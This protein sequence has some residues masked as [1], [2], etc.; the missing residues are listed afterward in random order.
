MTFNLVLMLFFSPFSLRDGLN[1]VGFGFSRELYGRHQLLFF[2]SDLLL[3]NLNLL[4]TLNDL[5]TKQKM[6]SLITLT[7]TLESGVNIIN[8]LRA[9]FKPAD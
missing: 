1:F 8:I 6:T 4:S 2:P 9:A 3:F 5:E 7:K